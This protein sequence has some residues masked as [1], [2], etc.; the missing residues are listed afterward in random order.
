MASDTSANSDRQGPEAASDT[1]K[2]GRAGAALPHDLA[3]ALGEYRVALERPGGPL[4]AGTVRVYKSR[5]GGFLGW[6]L[7]ISSR[8]DW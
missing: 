6:Q 4:G 8:A 2:A 7:P 5:V 3:A 1:T